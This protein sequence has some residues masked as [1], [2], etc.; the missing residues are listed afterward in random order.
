MLNTYCGA[1]NELKDKILKLSNPFNVYC[2][3][4]AQFFPQALTICLKFWNNFAVT[5]YS[6]E[7]S[8]H[9]WKR[10]KSYFIIK[11]SEDQL[12]GLALSF[13]YCCLS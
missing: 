6:D 1:T 10:V 7:K 9:Y 11:M 2:R 8:L 13:M 4:V 12:V 5:T 3:D